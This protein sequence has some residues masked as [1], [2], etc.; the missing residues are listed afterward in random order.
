MVVIYGTFSP[1]LNFEDF[2]N[3]FKK[4]IWRQGSNRKE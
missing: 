1:K 3:I 2:W 4:K